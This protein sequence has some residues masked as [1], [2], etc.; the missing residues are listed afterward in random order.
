MYV[1]VFGD[2]E[3]SIRIGEV[4]GAETAYFITYVLLGES[5]SAEISGIH[6]TDLQL[7]KQLSG[8]SGLVVTLVVYWVIRWTRKKVKKGSE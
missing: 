3:N 6:D 7:V 5:F 2:T 4:L 1:S 8:F